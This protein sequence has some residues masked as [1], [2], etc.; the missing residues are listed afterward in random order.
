[1]SYTAAVTR[2]DGAWLA[3]VRG[4]EGAHTFARNLEALDASVREVIALVAD[5]EAD[6][7]E[8]AVSYDYLGV[9]EDFLTAA[10]L[11]EERAALDDKVR[12]LKVAA[13]VS[14]EK[15]AR[16]GY[17]VRDIGGALRLSPGRVSQIMADASIPPAS[18]NDR[19]PARDRK[20]TITRKAGGGP[21]KTTIKGK[22]GGNTV[23]SIE[24]RSKGVNVRSAAARSGSFVSPAAASHQEAKD[25]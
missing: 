17:S 15:L 1:M 18:T 25:V 6:V 13:L 14:V 23:V 3:S 21:W 2:E 22:Q 8:G 24:G 4:L 20:G 19:G 9:S 11:G 16:E 7:Y 10:R 12:Q 5:L